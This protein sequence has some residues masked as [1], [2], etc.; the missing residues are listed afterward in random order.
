MRMRRTGRRLGAKFQNPSSKRRWRRSA[1]APLRGKQGIANFD[2]FGPIMTFPFFYLFSRF[3]CRG[4]QAWENRAGKPLFLVWYQGQSRSVKVSQ[5]QSRSVK[6]SQGQ[7]RS[8]KVSQGQSRSVK[9]SQG[10]SRSVKVSQGQSRSVKVSQGQSRSVKVSQGQSRSVKVSQGQSR[11]A[12]GKIPKFKF[13]MKMAALC[14]GAATWANHFEFAH[15]PSAGS[16]VSF[17]GL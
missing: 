12:K 2:Q 14:R 4:R 10:Q 15:W 8:V 7:S 9:V 3:D 13:Q 6:V 17:V 11:Y 1:E 16:F 5:G